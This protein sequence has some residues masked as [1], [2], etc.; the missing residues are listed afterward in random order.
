[1][2]QRL[3]P[4]ISCLATLFCAQG[5]YAQTPASKVEFEV[6]S[7]RTAAPIT[8]QN[9][10]SGKLRIG[11]NVNNTQAEYMGMSLRELIPIAF[12][13]KSYQVS[14]PDSIGEQRFE[15]QGKLPE[16]ANPD[17]AP[18]MLQALLADRFKLNAHRETQERSVYALTVPKGGHK[19]KESMPEEAAPAAEPAAAR[20][21]GA[22]NGQQ[23]R[24]T[25]GANGATLKGPNGTT[26]MSMGP[27]MTMRMEMSKMSMPALADALT[28]M[29]DRPVLDMTGLAGNFQVALEMSMQDMMAMAR[30]SGVLA[31]LGLPGAAGGGPAGA[32][33]AA[34]AA[35][36]SG[37]SVFKAVQ[38]LGLKLEGRKAPIEI[39]VI[40]HVEKSPTDN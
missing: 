40:D 19:M 37:D 22:V 32:G 16:G 29:L 30:A 15:I 13:V 24:V 5:M 9:I 28:R 25:N 10:Q 4:A 18:E 36:P 12:R 26:K 31:N 34:L 11:V 27:N 8:V 20:E 14:G 33:P 7:I 38:D 21:I 17:Q 35:N 2:F 6:A 23:I 3:L 1:M 39:L